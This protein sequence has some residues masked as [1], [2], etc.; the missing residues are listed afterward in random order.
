[1]IPVFERVKT[2]RAFDRAATV[3]GF[4]VYS[5]FQINMRVTTAVLQLACDILSLLLKLH[6]VN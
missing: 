3:I 6:G 2:L 5:I 1:M 4:L